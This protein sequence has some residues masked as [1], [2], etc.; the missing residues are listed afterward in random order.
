MSQEKTRKNKKKTK[1]RKHKKNHK[2]CP[3]MARSQHWTFCFCLNVILKANT[4]FSGYPTKIPK[5]SNL[6]NPI[7]CVSENIIKVD[8]GS[9]L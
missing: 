5:A 6:G 7:C 4:N 2:D 9:S 3:D 8:K 1:P